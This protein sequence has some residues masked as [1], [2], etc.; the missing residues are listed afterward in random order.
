[1]KVLGIAGYSGSGKTTLVVRLIPELKRRGLSVST[2]K[3]THHNVAIDRKDSVSR[4][5]CEAGAVDVVAA[6]DDHWALMHEHRGAPEPSLEELAA[7]MDPVDILLVEGFKKH[8]HD[9]IE[10]HRRA[11]GKTLLCVDDPNI[12]AIA[13]D[14]P[15][16][17]VALPRLDLDDIAAIADFI[18]ERT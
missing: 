7:H 11:T 5:L 6:A 17:G 2:V 12:V 3:H 1:M 16:E 9:K 14:A 10:V 15:V 13:S 4:R 18:L 8:D